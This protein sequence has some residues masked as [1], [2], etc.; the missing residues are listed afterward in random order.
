MQLKERA[1]K[2]QQAMR[3]AD[4]G[5]LVIAKEVLTVVNHWDKFKA[6]AGGLDVGPWLGKVFGAGRKVKY[7]ST[8]A[9]AVDSLG[10]SVRRFMHHEVAIWVHQ[11]V[12]AQHRTKFVKELAAARNENGGNPVSKMQ[13]AR[14]YR[15]VFGVATPAKRNH[16]RERCEMLERILDENGIEYP[17]ER[18]AEEAA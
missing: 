2:W 9:E 3:N 11:T 16:W 6:D 17:K 8:R 12:P 15:Q 13:A 4:T 18:E 10:K 5:P 14:L 1:T 7:W